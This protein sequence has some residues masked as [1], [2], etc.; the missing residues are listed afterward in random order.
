M[1]WTNDEWLS[2]VHRVVNP[3]REAASTG[4]LSIP[5]FHNPNADAVIECILILWRRQDCE[6]S[7]NSVCRSLPVEIQPRPEYEGSSRSRHE[8]SP[9]LELLARATNLMDQELARRGDAVREGNERV[10]VPNPAPRGRRV[11]HPHRPSLENPRI[12]G[13]LPAITAPTSM[14]I[15]PALPNAVY[16]TCCSSATPLKC[17]RST[18][19]IST[20]PCVWASAGRSTT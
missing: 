3:P 10:T 12:L 16:L 6:V 15:S 4:R 9:L 18:A 11:V 8:D 13:G 14:R 7:V 2:N 5:F 1:R 19:A 17:R 20:P